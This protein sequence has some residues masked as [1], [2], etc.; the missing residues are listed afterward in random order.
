MGQLAYADGSGGQRRGAVLDR[1]QRPAEPPAETGHQLVE[2]H[3]LPA[4]RRG[5]GQRGGPAGQRLHAP[6]P[7]AGA[8]GAGPVDDQMPEFEGAAREP[9]P[10]PAVQDQPGADAGADSEVQQ[11]RTSCLGRFAERGQVAVVGPAHGAGRK[12]P[13]ELGGQVQPDP[14]RPVG[15]GEHHA[16]CVAG[17]RQRHPDCRDRLRAPAQHAGHTAGQLRQ[18]GRD[19]GRRPPEVGDQPCVGLPIGSGQLGS[20][21]DLRATD[22][23]PEIADDLSC[24]GS[25]LPASPAWS[26]RRSPVGATL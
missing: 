10:A 17:S 9:R 12:Q 21:G 22:V 2:A 14:T 8:P 16:G 5:P 3:R 23:D 13:A 20:K 1:G 24:S 18:I 11:V 4:Q 15:P 6:P 19:A 7:P 26:Q 25:A